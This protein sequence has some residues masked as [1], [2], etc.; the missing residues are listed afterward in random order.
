ML[1]RA[2]ERK[3]DASL[4]EYGNYIPPHLLVA[5]TAQIEGDRDEIFLSSLLQCPSIQKWER[6]ERGEIELLGKTEKLKHEE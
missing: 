4:V 2:T 1:L 3:P 5:Y 6:K